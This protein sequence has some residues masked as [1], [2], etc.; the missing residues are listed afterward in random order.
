MA[1]LR[2]KENNNIYNAEL[3]EFDPMPGK[4]RKRIKRNRAIVRW[5]WISFL[6][7]GSTIFLFLLLIYNG[8]IG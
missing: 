5:L 2:M 4:S 8:V 3:E 7:I 6:S 1:D